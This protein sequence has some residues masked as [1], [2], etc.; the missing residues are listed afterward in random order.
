MK[1][2]SCLVAIVV[3]LTNL[4]VLHAGDSEELAFAD[5]LSRRNW[6][7]WAAEVASSLAASSRTESTVRAQSAVLH[8]QIVRRQAALTNDQGLEAKARRLEEDYTR[9]GLISPTSTLTLEFLRQKIEQ[10]ESLAAKAGV[11]QD[12]KKRQEL[13]ERVAGM[14]ET[15]DREFGAFVG[16]ARRA[17]GAYPPKCQWSAWLETAAQEQKEEF[18]NKVWKRDYAEYLHASSFIPYSRVVPDKRKAETVTRGLKK[19]L[20]YIDGEKENPEDFD[21]PAKGQNQPQEPDVRDTFPLLEYFAGISFGQCYLELGQYDKAIWYFD[22]LVQVEVP[23]G[24]EKS[25][26]D[27][28]R[29]VN[30]RLQ[31]YY[32]EGLAYNLAN[33]PVHAE[34]II[35]DMFEQSGKEIQPDRP[36]ILEY[37]KEQNQP[38]VA[39]MPDIRNHAF[40]K[41]SAFQL[42]KALAAQG[43]H[44]AAMEEVYGIFRLERR[45]RVSARETGLEV[46][47]AKTMADLSKKSPDSGLPMGAEFGVARGFHYMGEW[48]DAL[49]HYKRVYGSPGNTQDMREYA[50]EALLELG[51]LLYSDHRYFEAAIAFAEICRAFRDFS[52]IDLAASLLKQ[53]FQKAREAARQAG[54]SGDFETEALKKARGLA[55]SIYENRDVPKMPDLASLL[56][57]RN[58]EEVIEICARV[59]K[60]YEVE[61]DGTKTVRP[62]SFCAYARAQEGYCWYM[63]YLREKEDKPET[64]LEHL[65]EAMGALREALKEAPA[66]QDVRAEIQARYYLAKCLTEDVWAQPQALLNAREALECLEPFSDRLKDSASARVYVADVTATQVLACAVMEDYDR[67]H[68]AFEELENGHKDTGV[69]RNTCVKLYELLKKR[70]DSKA[71]IDAKQAETCFRE[72]AFFL[73]KFFK[74]AGKSLSAERLLRVGSGLY[75]TRGFTEAAEVLEACLAALPEQT[76]RSREQRELADAA[77]V[78]L[79][80]SRYGAGNY[81]AAAGLFDLLRRTVACPKCGFERILRREDFDKSP[82]VCPACKERGSTLV[83]VNELSLVV[84]E[85]AAESYLVLYETTGRTDMVALDR[86]QD[87]YQKILQRFQKTGMEQKDPG[88]YWEITCTVVRIWFYQRRF[89]HIVGSVKNVLLPYNDDW[90]KAIPVEHWRQE[91]R[92][93]FEACQKAL[94]RK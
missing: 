32:L 20:R 38:E 5:G 69:F 13:N 29:V 92:R 45:N 39:Q 35:R 18:Y 25:I 94:E 6:L 74:A 22:V 34:K 86:A 37:W 93:T 26:E 65:K 85:G 55:A 50:P 48:D 21:P 89:D 82:E 1:R 66:L 75:E 33:K 81:E 72:A 87:I 79:A 36:G 73:Y 54:E 49:Y 76:K 30:I 64:A 62:V 53:S 15:L 67:M 43:K 83:K 27:I 8:V 68:A 46:E 7:D 3:L 19:F 58:Y 42:A 2:L 77:K 52:K 44:A 84:Q 61:E 90:V 4:P 24:L 56:S 17:L 10:A 70:A 40:G 88:K 63:L 80:Q 9:S 78:L 16:E 91:I 12:K 59:S 51:K 14:F 47:A 28:A 60:T 41:L 57:A 23:Y 31:A 71:T 11:E